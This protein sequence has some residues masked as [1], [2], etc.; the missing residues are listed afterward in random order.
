M[1]NKKKGLVAL[2]LF[3]VLAIGIGYAAGASA[4]ATI[5]GQ[6]SATVGDFKI[7]FDETATQAIAKDPDS[8]SVDASYTGENTA[9][10]TVS[11]L[12]KVGDSGQATFTVKNASA[13][14]AAKIAASIT[15]DIDDKTHYKVTVNTAEGSENVQAKGKTTVTVKVELVKAFADETTA[16]TA[17]TFTVTVTGTAV[18]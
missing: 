12:K 8:V 6:A 17:K 1:K 7:I 3:L 13:S 9:T 16:G 15:K 11:G 2:V 4:N 10:I 5:N 14:L 18:E